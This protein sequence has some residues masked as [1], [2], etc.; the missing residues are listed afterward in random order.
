MNHGPKLEE[1]LAFLKEFPMK[2]RRRGL[3]CKGKR[4]EERKRN[5]NGK[6]NRGTGTQE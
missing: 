6:R 3:K 4:L 1:G 5:R 2:C